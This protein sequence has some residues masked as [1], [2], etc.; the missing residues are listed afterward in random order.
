MEIGSE[1]FFLQGEMFFDTNASNTESKNLVLA[2][3]L[4]QNLNKI[5]NWL[6][7]PEPQIMMVICS[8]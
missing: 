3:P 8:F 2:S 5:R 7:V 1:S 4:K 6:E